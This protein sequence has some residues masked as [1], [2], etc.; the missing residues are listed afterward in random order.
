M[1]VF[2]RVPQR[3][4][5]GGMVTK[6]CTEVICACICLR[7]KA[8]GGGEHV[9]CAGRGKQPG[10]RLF[11]M[12]LRLFSMSSRAPDEKIPF[13]HTVVK[14][15]RFRGKTRSL[16]VQLCQIQQFFVWCSVDYLYTWCKDNQRHAAFEKDMLLGVRGHTDK[17]VSDPAASK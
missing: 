3:E 16:T 7:E 2:V 11:S 13:A 1:C 17:S 10:L 14:R 9:Q 15:L 8:G 4:S 12:S 5:Q 6:M